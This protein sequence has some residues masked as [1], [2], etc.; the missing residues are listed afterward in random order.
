MKETMNDLTPEPLT[1]FSR[2]SANW[3]F[4]YSHRNKELR[5]SF[6]P[7]YGINFILA[8][9]AVPTLSVSL[10]FHRYAAFIRIGKRYSGIPA[11]VTA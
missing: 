10:F 3:F 5:N 11:G 8:L 1:A 7:Q 6:V 9:G 2:H 4:T